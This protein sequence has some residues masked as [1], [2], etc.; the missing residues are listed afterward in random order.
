MIIY[1]ISTYRHQIP[2]LLNAINAKRICEVGVRNGEHL[3]DLLT[4]VASQVVAVDLWQE[5]GKRSE[6]D[7]CHTQTELDEQC[8]NVAALSPRILVDRCSSVVAATHYH[9]GYF[10]FVYIDADHTEA[11]VEADIQAWWPK[12]R[13]GGILAGHDYYEVSPTCKDGTQ[14]NFGVIPAVNRFVESLGL[15]LHVDHDTDWFVEKP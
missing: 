11:A 1:L 13:A 9:D 15:I 10:D 7:E 6:N 3:V 12:V 2:T 8:I 14:I 5:T 4:S